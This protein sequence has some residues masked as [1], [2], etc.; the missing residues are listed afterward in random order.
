MQLK[1]LVDTQHGAENIV[2]VPTLKCVLLKHI[3][4]VVP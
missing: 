1:P 3:P 4:Y 2:D